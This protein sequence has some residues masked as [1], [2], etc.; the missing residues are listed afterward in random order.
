MPACSV[1]QAYR[2]YINLI[3]FKI[4]HARIQ[5]SLILITYKS[6]LFM[7]ISYIKS[8]KLI[9]NQ[10]ITSLSSFSTAWN[11]LYKRTS[12]LAGNIDGK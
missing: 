2:L 6:Y 12:Y 7:N 11:L 9:I 4:S 10:S 1:T 8:L 5:L 3:S